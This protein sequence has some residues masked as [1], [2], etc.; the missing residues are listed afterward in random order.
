V[1]SFKGSWAARFEDEIPQAAAELTDEQKA[2]IAAQDEKKEKAKREAPAFE[3]NSVFH[4]KEERDYQGRTYMHPPADQKTVG[5]DY[6]AFIPKKWIHTWYAAPLHTLLSPFRSSLRYR[7]TPLCAAA[8]AGPATTK[9]CSASSGFR[10][11][12]ICC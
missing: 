8:D 4:G 9:A 2:Y 11:P 6:K 12:V 7:L 1:C 10:R 5:A 3:E